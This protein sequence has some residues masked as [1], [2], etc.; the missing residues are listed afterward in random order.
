MKLFIGLILII[1]S[2]LGFI[3]FFGFEYMKLFIGLA[4]IGIGL[5][6]LYKLLDFILNS[7][8][9]QIIKKVLTILFCILFL[10]V[11]LFRTSLQNPTVLFYE[12]HVRNKLIALLFLIYIAIYF[13]LFRK[14]LS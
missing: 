2:T 11:M 4:L 6:L 8:K 10:P 3:Y 5:L 12:T 7:I 13:I 14:I 1:I 9:N